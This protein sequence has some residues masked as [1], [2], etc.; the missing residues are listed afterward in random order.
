[1]MERGKQKT[2]MSE[3]QTW[4]SLILI[5]YVFMQHQMPCL[6]NINYV[7]VRCSF[8]IQNPANRLLKTCKR[9]D[10]GHSLFNFW[11]S[12]KRY[13]KSLLT[14]ILRLT[15]ALNY[16]CIHTVFVSL[17]QE[18]NKIFIIKLS[19]FLESYLVE[20]NSVKTQNSRSNHVFIYSIYNKMSYLKWINRGFNSFDTFD[21]YL[22]PYIHCKFV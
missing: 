6:F 14:F 4:I 9:I 19:V 2:C 7:V 18:K 10:C 11:I 1:M 13:E 21:V 22:M 5:L 16:I 15:T 17:L 3:N 12:E 20:N 8:E